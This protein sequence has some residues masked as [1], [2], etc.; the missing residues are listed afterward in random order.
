MKEKIKKSEEEWREALT[1]EEFYVLRKKGTEVAFTGKYLDNKKEG[2]Y[3]CAGCGA[4]LFS[5]KTKYDS[6][7]GWPSFW[8]PISRENLDTKID[9]SLGTVRIELLCSRCGGHL[10]HVFTDGP[11]PTGERYC[12]NSV[13][14]KFKDKA[15]KAKQDKE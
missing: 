10:G 4:E 7:S 12:I 8:E 2:I 13:S 6:G 11:K 3:L 9:K 14:L 5:S 15:K 1:E